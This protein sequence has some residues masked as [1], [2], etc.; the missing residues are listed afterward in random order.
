M[1]KT[2]VLIT[3]G[4]G[5]V[6]RHLMDALPPS[7]FTVYGTTYP[8]PPRAWE[9]NI[10]YADLRSEREVHDAV[11][12]ARPQWIVHLAAVSNVRQSWEKRRET[13]ETNVMGTFYLL[14]AVKKFA[15]DARLLFVSSS[16][17]YGAAAPGESAGGPALS[18]AD[19]FHLI[20]PYALSKFGGELFCGFYGRAD[21]LDIVIAR[22]FPH[23]GPGQGP[24][25]VCSDWARQI[26]QIERGAQEPVLTVGN[27]DVE[28]DFTDVRDVVR[29]YVLLMQK[30]KRG[31]VYNVCRG[32]AVSL[33][34]ILDIYIT[35]ARKV[36]TARQDPGKLRPVDICRL[37]GDNRKIRR[38]TG[39]EPRIPLEQ[40]LREILDY[41]R[42][43]P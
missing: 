43:H 5:F 32:E 39:W 30:G 14:E 42:A 41:W 24:D 12:L 2:R 38:A 26:I 37:V 23:T 36:I 4:T 28:R 9:K 6:G 10:L 34:R 25:F 16:D 1:P 8:L 17:I 18:E 35:Q 3:G 21:S 15:A 27:I 11:K 13:I 19:P 7:D 20:D 31:E 22:P 40:T 29:A 33:R